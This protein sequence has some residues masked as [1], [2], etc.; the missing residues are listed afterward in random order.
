LIVIEIWN[1][2]GDLGAAARSTAR[3]RADLEALAILAGGDEGAY[4]VAIGWLLVDTA[5]NRRLVATYPSILRA[6]FLG[7]SVVWVRCLV[8][9]TDPPAQPA[10]AWIDVPNARL[11]PVRLR[12]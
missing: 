11:T 9:G 7:S 8:A 6:S 4:Q 2:F 12:D 5:A 10:L 3:K 1:R